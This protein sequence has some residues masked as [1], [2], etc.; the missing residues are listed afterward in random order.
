MDSAAVARD[1]AA[2]LAAIQSLGD[3]AEKELTAILTAITRRAA[4]HQQRAALTARA[5]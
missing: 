2:S 3:P 4:D 5:R 1:A